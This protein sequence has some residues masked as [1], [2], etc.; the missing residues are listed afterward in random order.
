MIPIRVMNRK[1]A[2]RYSYSNHPKTLIISIRDNGSRIPH[3]VK[4]NLVIFYFE[5]DDV[6]EGD[7]RGIL[8]SDNQARDI[9][10]A[11]NDFKGRVDCAVVHCE[12]G[13]SRSAG[14]LRLLEWL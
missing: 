2:I 14:W 7:T 13:I 5:F 9:A 10:V 8:I 12:A 1:Q 6:E 11:V 3:F 4:D